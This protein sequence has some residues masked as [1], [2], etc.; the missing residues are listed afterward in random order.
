M[1]AS[2]LHAPLDSGESKRLF[3]S[4]ERG[5]RG[6]STVTLMASCTSTSSGGLVPMLM[7]SVKKVP[8]NGGQIARPTT[9][10][11]AHPGLTCWRI[12]GQ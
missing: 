2:M 9:W 6:P 8:V 5:V 4:R 1:A 7:T 11:A 10:R 3:G 12:G